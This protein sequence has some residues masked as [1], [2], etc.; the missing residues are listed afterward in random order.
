MEEISPDHHQWGPRRYSWNE[1]KILKI[2][3]QR[4]K[5]LLPIITLSTPSIQTSYF[6]RE[7][8]LVSCDFTPLVPGRVL[9]ES[10]YLGL[11]ETEI[12][13]G[14]LFG[15]EC[16]ILHSSSD[17]PKWGIKLM[18]REQT[19][20]YRGSWGGLGSLMETLSVLIIYSWTERPG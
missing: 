19:H 2:K 15:G 4:N 3:L 20:G 9:F 13:L 14:I 6:E 8:N 5:K 18:Q 17:W 1:A 10:S 16:C 11:V 7:N 12:P